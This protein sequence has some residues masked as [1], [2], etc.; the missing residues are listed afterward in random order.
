MLR[1]LNPPV[2]R[3]VAPGLV[4]AVVTGGLV[5]C[6]RSI[7]PTEPVPAPSTS[8]SPAASAHEHAVTAQAP[9]SSAAATAAAAAAGDEGAAVGVRL[10]ALLGQHTVLA[11]DMMRARIRRDPDFAQAAEDALTRNSQALGTL[12]GSVFGADAAATFSQAWAGHVTNLFEYA[13]AR[14]SGDAP[15]LQRA[16][17]QLKAAESALGSFVAS[18]SNGRLTVADAVAGMRMHVEGLLAQA[19]A[20][21]KGDHAAAADAYQH[22]FQH[23]YALGATLAS[24]LLPKK[25]VAALATPSWQLRTNL[26]EALGEHVALVIAAMRAA[27]GASSSDFQS[28]GKALNHNT[29]ALSGAV[30]TLFG[31]PAGAQ[32]QKLW[33]DHVDGLMTVTSATAKGDTAQQ[34][35]GRQQLR[36]FEPA[37]AAFLN[38]ATQSRIGADALARAL[39]MHDEMLLQEVQAFQAKDYAK[40]H[41]LGYS[42]YD[43]MFDLA[44]QLS[45]AIELTLG[46]K[47]P[48]GGSQTGGGGMA[49]VVGRR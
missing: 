16:R 9:A 47:L 30:G 1:I 41:D 12:V 7:T 6:G 29:Q 35:K 26:T 33:A 36:A 4:L 10:Q 39:A 31:A 48:R 28:L 37:L 46:A 23:T 15:A 24:A 17:Q 25:D 18:A 43:E 20:Y 3:F 38:G 42:A 27:S 2:G 8:S 5:G 44:A 19:D 22:A 32:F 40:A 34:E 45:H 13:E 21:A 49:G 14:Q 11:A